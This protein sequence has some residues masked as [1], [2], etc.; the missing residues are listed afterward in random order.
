[1]QQIEVQSMT[2][3]SVDTKTPIHNRLVVL[4]GC[5]FQC[6]YLSVHV[7][8]SACILS[9][10]NISLNTDVAPCD[11]CM[12]SCIWLVNINDTIL[13]THKL[14]DLLRVAY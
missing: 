2:T 3:Y 9:T 6:R 13:L 5:I 7:H 8:C 4:L 10:D 1:M 14:L 11:A 12:P